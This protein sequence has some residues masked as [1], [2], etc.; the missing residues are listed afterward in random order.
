MDIRFRCEN[1]ETV[2][3]LRPH[4]EVTVPKFL[5]DWEISVVGVAQVVEHRVVAPVAVGSSPIAHPIYSACSS[6]SRTQQRE[7][8]TWNLEL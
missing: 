6:R 1:F 2:P 8:G 3:R 5:Y 4:N 7:S